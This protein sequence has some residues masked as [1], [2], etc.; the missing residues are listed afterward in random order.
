MFYTP[1]PEVFADEG[2]RF[3][4]PLF[5]F[6]CL[7]AAIFIVAARTSVS[8]VVRGFLSFAVKQETSKEA[9]KHLILS[10]ATFCEVLD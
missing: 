1:L 5:C 8:P 2:M 4:S 6:L 3:S 7:I 10:S 9:S